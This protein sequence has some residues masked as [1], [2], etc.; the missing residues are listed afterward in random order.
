MGLFFGILSRQTEFF[1]MYANPTH[2]LDKAI[3]Y[4]QIV[5]TKYLIRVDNEITLE[6]K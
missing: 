6:N 2:F 3:F 5:L 1:F 4:L